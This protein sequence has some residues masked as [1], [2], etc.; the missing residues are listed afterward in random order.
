MSLKRLK[1]LLA[2][3]S[4]PACL[5]FGFIMR[6]GSLLAAAS[7]LPAATPAPTLPDGPG[8]QVTITVCGKCHSPERAAA[9]HQ[10]RRAWA[11]TISKMVSMGAVASDEQLNTVL[12]Y[13]SKNFPPPPRPP[14]NI[15][16]ATPVEMESS[17]LLLKSEA[18]AIVQYRTEHGKFKSLDDLRKVPRL[19]FQ[20]IEGKKGRITFGE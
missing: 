7:L 10:T 5:R 13:L 11:D 4:V 8:K 1:P 9:L 20:K 2:P 6:F 17:L 16:T 15:N 14:V 18:A 12:D 3:D 19:N